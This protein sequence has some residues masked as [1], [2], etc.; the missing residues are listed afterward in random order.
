MPDDSHEIKL[1]NINESFWSW[2]VL[3]N[4]KSIQDS[5]DFSAEVFNAH[6]QVIYCNL[7]STWTWC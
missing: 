5:S 4:F 3:V 1:D 2:A 7:I 6:A